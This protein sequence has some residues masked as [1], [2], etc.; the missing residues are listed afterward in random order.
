ML[1]RTPAVSLIAVLSLALGIGA[2]TAIFSLIDTVMLKSLPVREPARLVLLSNPDASGISVGTHGGERELFSYGEFE[3]IRD[4]QQV[5][6]G[7]FAAQSEAERQSA[8]IDGGAPE[9]VRERLVSGAYFAVLGVTP[10]IGRAFGETDDRVPHGAPYAVI[11]YPF[12]ERRFGRSADVLGKRIE[13]GKASLSVIGVAPPGFFG[14]T[15]G[16]PPDV[17]IPMMMQPDVQPGRNFLKDNETEVT[18]VE[19]LQMMGRLKPGATLTQAQANIG[20]VF[21]QL[22]ASYQIP[23]LSEDQRHALLNQTVKARAGG[24]GASSVRGDFGQPLMVLM[25]LVGLVLLIACANIA[26]LLLARAAGR[27]KEIA[28]RMALGASRMQLGAQIMTESILLGTAGGALGVGLAA[29]ATR[30]LVRL[31]AGGGQLRL[32][33]HTDWRVLGFTAAVALAT[34][35]LFGLAPALRATRIDVAPALKENARGV[36]SGSRVTLGR[37]LVTA[38]IAISLLLLIGAGLFVRTLRNLQNVDLGYA[39]ENLVVVRIDSLSAGYHGEAAVGL[40]N[41]LLDEIRAVPGVRNATYSDNGIFSGSSC[42]TQLYIEG[43]TPAK[44]AR[45][46]TR[47]EAIGPGYFS[48]LGV[49]MMRGRELTLADMTPTS[50]VCV[51]NQAMAKDFFEGRDPI[52]KHI[53]DLYPGSK[54]EYEI[55]GVA[56]DFRTDSLRGKVV[57]HFYAPAA[58]AI[59]EGVPPGI[60]FEVRTVAAPGSVISAVRRKIQE[61]DRTVPM[62]DIRT[63]EER[64]DRRVLQQ[65]IIAELSSFFGVLALL[66]AAIGLYGVLSH[67]VARR[68]NEIGIRMAVGA[69]RGAVAWMVLREML[70]MLAVGAAAGGTAAVGLSRLIASQMF[71]VKGSDPLTLAAAAATLAAIAVF[72]SLFPAMRAARVDPMTALR[73]E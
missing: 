60:E 54:A 44:G 26:N 36:T 68:T 11:S 23:N 66:L 31:V 39:R 62:E 73:V 33:A 18:R 55:V 57:R 4:K 37:A 41:R 6:D 70:A 13:M 61:T 40:Y 7:M 8:R 28:V 50:K 25:A 10:L 3:H 27:Q 45:T 15:V 2:N 49:P 21:K 65:R 58:N 67:A 9:D 19:W 69:G 32:D 22:L 16:D 63:V 52:G 14:E 59:G 12:W 34:G 51:I 42:G 48:A 35:I 30:L 17:W 38:Q 72:A 71:G 29:M 46:G 43:F 53:K 47:C 5:F 64:L 56:Q 1:A 20:L 24:K